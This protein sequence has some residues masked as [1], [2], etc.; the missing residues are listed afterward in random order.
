MRKLFTLAAF[1]LLLIGCSDSVSKTDPYE[2]YLA[3]NPDPS[4]ILTREE[5]QTRSLLGCH[6]KWAPGTIDAVLHDA[7]KGLC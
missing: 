3:N 5:A 2:T 6:T 1:A 4:I 7:Y